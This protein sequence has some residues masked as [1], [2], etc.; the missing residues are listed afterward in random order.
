MENILGIDIG[1]QGIKLR[2]EDQQGQVFTRIERYGKYNMEKLQA[3]ICQFISAYN[4]NVGVIG[5]SQTGIVS[6]NEVIKSVHQ[7]ELNGMNKGS[8]QNIGIE[9]TFILNDGKAM[10]YAASKRYRAKN[11]LAIAAGTGIACGIMSDGKTILGANRKSGEIHAIPV[12]TENGMISLGAL[13]SGTAVVRKFGLDYMKQYVKNSEVQEEI[14]KAGKYTGL[15]I[16]MAKRFLDPD[17][18]YLTG[19]ATAFEGYFE[20]AMDYVREN[21]PTIGE[22]KTVIAKSTDAF[23]DGCIGAEWYAHL[24][25]QSIL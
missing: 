17:V 21:M 16:I 4:I 15:H 14:K 19:G 23:F 25:K 20:A 11:I 9:S 24:Q 2:Y 5:I 10:V 8:F 22:E 7:P 1:G 3:S 18:I 6:N 13:C 12:M